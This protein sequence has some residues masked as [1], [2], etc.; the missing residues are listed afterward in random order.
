M[1]PTTDPIYDVQSM[2]KIQPLD[3][4][5]VNWVLYKSHVVT[6]IT[7][8]TGLKKDLTGWEKCP[9]PLAIVKQPNTVKSLFLIMARLLLVQIK[10]RRGCIRLT[11]GSSMKHL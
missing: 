9:L 2:N 3:G 11:I 10:L 8:K 5:G 7:S 4:D 6:L 1:S